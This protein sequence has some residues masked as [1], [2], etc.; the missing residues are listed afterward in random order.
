MKYSNTAI[1]KNL[2]RQECCQKCANKRR[3]Y[4]LTQQTAKANVLYDKK[5]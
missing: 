2:C 3:I 5:L 1:K 4:R